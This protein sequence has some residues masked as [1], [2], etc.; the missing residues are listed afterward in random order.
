MQKKPWFYCET[1][2]VCDTKYINIL[3]DQKNKIGAHPY[4]HGDFNALIFH[5]KQE[6]VT[7]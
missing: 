1:E 2:G 3:D 5:G 6:S 4:I 7:R